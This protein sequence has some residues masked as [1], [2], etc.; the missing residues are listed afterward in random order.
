MWLILG[1]SIKQKK[2]DV[3]GEESPRCKELPPYSQSCNVK[4]SI[5]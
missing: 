2:G 4:K 3:G 1:F 5:R